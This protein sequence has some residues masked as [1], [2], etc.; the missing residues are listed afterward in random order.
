MP[1]KETERVGLLSGG[2][3]SWRP[4]TLLGRAMIS[5]VTIKISWGSSPAVLDESPHLINLLRNPSRM[6][7][8]SLSREA[9]FD[10][11]IIRYYPVVVNFLSEISLF[12]TPW[13]GWTPGNSSS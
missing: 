4:T 5:W 11:S 3:I 12:A 7:N 8:C 13:S 9:L 6:S 10:L 2:L 1:E